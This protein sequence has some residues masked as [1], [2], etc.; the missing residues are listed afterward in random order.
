MLVPNSNLPAGRNWKTAPR[1][2]IRPARRP[3]GYTSAH[4][5][6]PGR[7]TT[8]LV[9]S[10]QL[11]APAVLPHAPHGLGAPLQ[12]R[13][14]SGASLLRRSCR[15]AA[16]GRARRSQGPRASLQ[17]QGESLA[18]PLNYYKIAGLTQMCSRDSLKNALERCAAVLRA[19]R[20]GGGVHRCRLVSLRCSLPAFISVQ[21][22]CWTSSQTLP[23]A[24]RA[25]AGAWP[26]RP[27]WA[28]ASSACSR[29]ARC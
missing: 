16:G 1:S 23:P 13:K 2:P 29:A 22:A 12:G 26:S 18:L 20:P 8:M 15:P 9:A 5:D 24:C 14:G 11:A 4:P 10:R 19:F 28:T 25:P 21:L 27:P 6:C 3:R 7:V 17:Q